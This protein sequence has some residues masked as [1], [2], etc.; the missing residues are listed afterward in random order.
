MK[1]TL[2]E[3]LQINLNDFF[4]RTNEYKSARYTYPSKKFVNLKQILITK[5]I[6]F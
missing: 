1:Y 3:S 6:I 2:E 5:K 4:E